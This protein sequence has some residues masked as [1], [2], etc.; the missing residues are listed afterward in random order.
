MD[1]VR[2]NL[3]ENTAISLIYMA[4]SDYYLHFQYYE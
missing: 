3:S 2:V 1:I 4:R